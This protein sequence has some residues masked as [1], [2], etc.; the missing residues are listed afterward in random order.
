MNEEQADNATARDLCWKPLS[1]GCSGPSSPLQ[2]TTPS[3][4]RSGRPSTPRSVW[5]FPCLP[6]S[7]KKITLAKCCCKKIALDV[8]GDNTST[9]TAHSGASKAHDWMVS[10][11]G[12]SSAPRDTG[13]ARNAQRRGD[14]EIR[15]YLRDQA[16]PRSL[17]FDL[18]VTYDRYGSSSHPQQNAMLTHPRDLDAPL[19]AA[20]QRKINRFRQQYADNHNRDDFFSLRL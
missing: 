6:L 3:T 9:C 8:H 18:S 1:D 14:V 16:G 13:G 2:P 7:Q 12:L 19:R 17:V 10:I 20:A 4:R 11:L 5:R 15:D